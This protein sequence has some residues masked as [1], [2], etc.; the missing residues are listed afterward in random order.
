MLLLDASV[1]V[2]HMTQEL[3]EVLQ[4]FWRVTAVLWYAP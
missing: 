2:G 1:I 3:L 4:H